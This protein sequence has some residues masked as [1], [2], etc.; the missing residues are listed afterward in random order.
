MVLNK[1][2]CFKENTRCVRFQNIHQKKITNYKNIYQDSKG[3]DLYMLYSLNACI[4]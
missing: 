1:F 4:K 2:S 3:E